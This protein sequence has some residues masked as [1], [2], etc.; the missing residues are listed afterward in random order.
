[1]ERRHW[2]DDEIKEEL[3]TEEHVVEKRLLIP[4]VA[5]TETKRRRRTEEKP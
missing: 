5:C 3:V 2:K 1:M 4:I